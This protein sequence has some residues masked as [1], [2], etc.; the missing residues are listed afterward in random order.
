MTYL[1]NKLI[2]DYFLNLMFLN[3]FKNINSDIK[4]YIKFYIIEDKTKFKNHP[5]IKYK[6]ILRDISSIEI[7]RSRFNPWD[8][9]ETVY[10]NYS[11]NF[12]SIKTLPYLKTML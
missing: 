8:F 11:L 4:Q 7:Q 1:S 3:K 5:I 2:N 9:N 6:K 10:F 12:V